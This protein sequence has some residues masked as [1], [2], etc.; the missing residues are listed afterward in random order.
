VSSLADFDL[1]LPVDSTGSFRRE[2]DSSC[3]NDNFDN[4]SPLVPTDFVE[5]RQPPFATTKNPLDP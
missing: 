4:A 1:T 2:N 5:L 3:L